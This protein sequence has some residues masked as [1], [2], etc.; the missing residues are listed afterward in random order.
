MLLLFTICVYILI[1]CIAWGYIP[2]FLIRKYADCSISLIILT[3]FMLLTVY[4]EICSLFGPVGAV[5]NIVM[6]IVSAALLIIRKK[7]IIKAIRGLISK[8]SKIEFIVLLIVYMIFALCAVHDNIWGDSMIY[9][10]SAVRWIEEYGAVKGIANLNPRFA[11]HSS[12]FSV[13][14]LFSMKWLLGM[15]YRPIILFL[16][17]ISSTM[18][19]DRLFHFKDHKDHIGDVLGLGILVYTMNA[20]GMMSSPATDYPATIIAFMGLMIILENI[21]MDKPDMMIITAVSL[22]FV[23]S[24]TLKL[25]QVFFALICIIPLVSFVKKKQY[26]AIVYSVIATGLIVVPWMIHNFIISG[27]WLSPSAASGFP[28]VSWRVPP[29]VLRWLSEGV[30]CFARINHYDFEKSYYSVP[31]GWIPMW[32]DGMSSGIRLL[33]GVLLLCVTVDVIY[34]VIYIKRIPHMYLCIKAVMIMALLFWFLKAPNFRFGF[35]VICFFVLTEMYD[36]IHRSVSDNR[37]VC[38]I[39]IGVFGLSCIV[40][41]LMFTKNTVAV[42]RQI[43]SDAHIANS[44]ICQPDYPIEEVKQ[45]E[46]KCSGGSITVYYPSLHAGYKMFPSC[47]NETISDHVKMLGTNIEEGFYFDGTAEDMY[48]A[49]F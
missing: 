17:C 16:A 25:S 4:A 13:M 27:Y 11:F 42:G 29:Q 34:T 45:A 30:T 9:Q 8:T 21:R 32:L 12:V 24:V 10:G 46:I 44:F 40:L 15:S 36:I 20:N 14:A 5:S 33:M 18:S 39:G 37:L 43:Y 35:A 28:R 38:G 47:Y 6:I 1:C 19:I 31:F 49:V 3:G 23:F 7:S 22:V 2:A 48:D 26:K 41:G